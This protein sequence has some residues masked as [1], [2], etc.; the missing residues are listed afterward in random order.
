MSSDTHPD[1]SSATEHLTHEDPNRRNSTDS[2]IIHYL[3]FE[4]NDGFFPP[5]WIGK[6]LERRPSS[7]HTGNDIG[8]KETST[9]A[10]KG[11]T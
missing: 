11:S 2:D 1:P 10:F 5:S 4:D 6:E 9:S 7:E 8:T 3:Y